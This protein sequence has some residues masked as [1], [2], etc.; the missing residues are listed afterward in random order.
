MDVDISNSL[1][2]ASGIFFLLAFFRSVFLF[3]GNDEVSAEIWRRHW[4]EVS[5]I[6]AT[7]IILAVIALVGN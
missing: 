2:Y 3:T 7:G 6:I 4:I 5:V 1:N